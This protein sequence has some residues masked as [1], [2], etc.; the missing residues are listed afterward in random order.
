VIG[1]PGELPIGVLCYQTVHCALST[2]ELFVS[3]TTH[4]PVAGVLTVMICPVE[5]SF[6]GSVGYQ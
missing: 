3:I 4:P 6:S 1:N 5:L 2:G